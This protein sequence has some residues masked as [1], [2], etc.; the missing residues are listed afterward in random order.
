MPNGS[1]IWVP[2][3]SADP[4]RGAYREAFDHQIE[5]LRQFQE[6]W[7]EQLEQLLE[8]IKSPSNEGSGAEPEK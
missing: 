4:V 1:R 2:A 6:R 5:N 7:F 8:P 3:E